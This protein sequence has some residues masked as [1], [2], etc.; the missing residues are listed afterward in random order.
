MTRIFLIGYMGAGKTTLG[1]ALAKELKIEFIDL[2]NY[3]EERLCKSISQIFAEKGEEGFRE[4]ERRML[5]EAG[6]FENV[7]ISTGGGT[8]C[9]FD[10]IEYMNRQGATVF[11]D[12]PVERLFIRLSIARKKRPLIMGKSDEELRCFIAEQL[13]KR[14][15]HYSKAKQR[16]TADRLED[17]KQIEASVKEF[18]QQIEL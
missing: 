14:L 4:I 2:D 8:P 3:I 7:V 6:E 15:P 10:N 13:A 1:R 12:V 17:V 9:F 16:F 5:H 18:L 11:L